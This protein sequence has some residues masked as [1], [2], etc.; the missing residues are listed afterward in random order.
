MATAFVG[1]NV[2]RS[3]SVRA[4]T[5]VKRQAGAQVGQGREPLSACVSL[6]CAEEEGRPPSFCSSCDPRSTQALTERLRL[7]ACSASWPGPPSRWWL[8]RR[9]RCVHRRARRTIRYLPFQLPARWWRSGISSII[10]APCS[11]LLGAGAGTR[12][13]GGGGRR[14]RCARRQPAFPPPPRPRLRC[15]EEQPL[16][17]GAE[18]H[19]QVHCAARQGHPRLRW[20]CLS[21]KQRTSTKKEV[22]KKLPRLDSSADPCVQAPASMSLSVP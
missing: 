4:G 14:P 18:G 13:P 17:G 3:T 12:R 22:K 1:A 5:P 8:P 19:R 7:G 10:Q 11:N 16:C 2:A 15:A 20:V 21:P 9:R 6:R